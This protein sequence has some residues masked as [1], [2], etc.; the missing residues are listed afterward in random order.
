[1]PGIGPHDIIIRVKAA[2]V[3]PVDWKIREGLLQGRL[4]HEFP[5]IPG[6]DAAGIV[7]KVGEQVTRF[8][9]N[10]PVMSYTRKE[11]IQGGTYAEYISVPINNV[12]LKPEKLSFEEAAALPLAGLTAYQSIF[13]ALELKSGETILIHAGAGG[14]GSYAIQLAKNAGAIVI[15]TASPSNHDYVYSLGADTV[16]DYNQE[17]FAQVIQ[18]KYPDG[19]DCVYDTMGETVQDKSISILKKGGRLCSIL[20]IPKE[21]DYKKQGYDISYVF[22]APQASQLETLGNLAQTGK[23]KIA[24]ASQL[25]LEQAALAHEHIETGHTQGKIVLTI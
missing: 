24:I 20:A 21:D 4:P 12:A 11:I 14:V 8:K 19:I 7:E 2:G 16:I 1:M 13:D 15:T 17:D 9:V 23:L 3:N 18:Q 25:P 10:D 6:W 22:V 5:I